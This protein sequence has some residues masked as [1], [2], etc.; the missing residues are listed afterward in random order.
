[1]KVDVF[2][3]LRLVIGKLEIVFDQQVLQ[4]QLDCCFEA[5]CPNVVLDE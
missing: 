5:V 4:D 2:R 1:M 3:T